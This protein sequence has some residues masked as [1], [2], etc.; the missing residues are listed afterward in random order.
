MKN[1]PAANLQ[2]VWMLVERAN[3]K[4]MLCSLELQWN[5]WQALG[6]LKSKTS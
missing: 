1:L 3:E 5:W 4:Q 2:V 6:R